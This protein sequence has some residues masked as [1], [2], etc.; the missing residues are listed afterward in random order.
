ME[1]RVQSH[2]THRGADFHGR[3][4]PFWLPPTSMHET[5]A[6]RLSMAMNEHV[7][8]GYTIR[9]RCGVNM[10]K[11]FQVQSEA[12]Y[13]CY[14]HS[15]LPSHHDPPYTRAKTPC[16][17]MLPISPIFLTLLTLI[18]V[19]ISSPTIPHHLTVNIILNQPKADKNPSTLDAECES[20]GEGFHPDP[21]DCARFFRCVDTGDDKCTSFDF[22]C[23]SCTVFDPQILTCNP[24]WSVD[25]KSECYGQIDMTK[26]GNEA[27]NPDL[28]YYKARGSGGLEISVGEG[29][30]EQPEC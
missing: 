23:P 1:S 29:G 26:T 9:D 15:N 22:I 30:S 11:D 24:S 21:R 12:R 28:K 4:S 6:T 3:V 27:V 16:P 19:I 10:E 2:V 5:K 14:L 17:A 18:T 25:P 7:R 13:I 8:L 20:L